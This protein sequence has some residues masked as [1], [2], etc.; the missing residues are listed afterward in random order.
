MDEWM[1]GCMDGY[2]EPAKK[3]HEWRQ[4]IRHRLISGQRSAASGGVTAEGFVGNQLISL[5]SQA[6]GY[7]SGLGARR[8]RVGN[9]MVLRRV[10]VGVGVTG[11]CVRSFVFSFFFFFWV[12]AFC[13]IY[14]HSWLA[15]WL[16]GGFWG[17]LEDGSR[18]ATRGL[19]FPPLSCLPFLVS[20]GGICYPPPSP[21]SPLSCLL[22]AICAFALSARYHFPLSCRFLF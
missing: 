12:A 21:P 16:G 10:G 8:N 18:C 9:R 19:P 11:L 15:G 7:P 1:D 6:I 13:C 20:R 4:Q 14:I 3:V 2:T 22:S 17:E 5:Q